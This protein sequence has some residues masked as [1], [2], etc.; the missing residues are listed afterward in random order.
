[1]IKS[2][3][4]ILNEARHQFVTNEVTLAH[5]NYSR[6]LSTGVPEG[7][8][9]LHRMT[10][11]YMYLPMAEI[12]PLYYFEYLEQA[13]READEN[14]Q[15]KNEYRIA[16]ETL[17]RIKDMFLRDIALNYFCEVCTTPW[18]SNYGKSLDELYL[19]INRNINDI[20]DNDR[21][22]L[23]A[24]IPNYNMNQLRYDLKVIQ[25]YCLNLLLMYTTSKSTVY[26]GKKYTASTVVYDNFA[27]TQVS[28]HDTYSHNAMA[29]PR[30]HQLSKEQYYP[31]C[32]QAFNQLKK[33]L[34]ISPEADLR[35]EISRLVDRK[36]PKNDTEKE[37]FK[38]AK[39]LAKDDPERQS[40]YNT[41]G[42]LYPGY[43]TIV[44]PILKLCW[45]VDQVGK[46]ELDQP[47]TRK[48]FLGVCNML[49][50]ANDWSVEMVRTV[51]FI[52]CLMIVGI[53]AYFGLFI[54]M[55]AK[56]FL[57]NFSVEKHI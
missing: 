49:A 46:F 32:L 47:F 25:A 4:N 56:F 23:R 2:S 43:Q 5:A 18:R 31:D 42:R 8:I 27:Y 40:F 57:T 14:V 20:V 7:I 9:N 1:M 22:A 11:G 55:K 13:K 3:Y 37:Y 12:S 50:W 41:F 45:G 44:K 15:Y 35:K 38:Y 10:K 19:Y 39:N 17:V 52:S 26:E 33:E 36:H 24:Y 30:L 16:L 53:F 21:F 29:R 48:R 6:A 54:A 28:S 51:M 34:N